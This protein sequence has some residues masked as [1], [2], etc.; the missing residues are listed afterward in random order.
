MRAQIRTQAISALLIG[1]WVAFYWAS[2]LAQ[3]AVSHVEFTDA[4]PNFSVDA[5]NLAAEDPALTHLDLYVKLTHQALQFIRTDERDFRADYAVAVEAYDSEGEK[6][7]ST[8]A[9]ETLFAENYD[10]TNSREL[11]HITRLGLDLEP[12]EYE[13]RVRVLDRETRKETAQSFPMSLRSYPAQGLDVSDIVYL[14]YLS[15]D[16]EGRLH[17]R[18]MVQIAKEASAEI[19]AYFEVYNVPENEDI[20]ISY[21]LLDARKEDVHVNE[22]T[23]KSRGRVTPYHI[24][25]DGGELPP[26]QYQL[27][28]DVMYGDDI[29]ETRRELAWFWQGLPEEFA[30]LHKA[31]EVLRYIASKEEMKELQEAPEEEK[32][33]AF[34][35]FWA[36]RDPTPGT[37]AN[38]LMEEY[39]RRIKYANDHFSGFKA[40]WKTDMGMVYVKLGPPDNIERNPYN[41]NYA[42]LPGRT[43]KAL[44]V[45]TYQMHNRNLV[46]LDENG[47]GEY[48][49]A[50][51][52]VFYDIVR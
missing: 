13:I 30:D 16:E 15:T 28:V 29:V 17:F 20:I 27:Q 21:E 47:F 19:L 9:E 52:H 39:Y 41:Q 26:G 33:D 31:I 2:G 44:E 35:Q 3:I 40:G 25:I 48:R 45:W 5:L 42:F 8:S 10:Q 51:P 1:A 6:V 50:N 18:P 49:L 22:V 7:G 23:V 12:G 36:E 34:I 14:D 38:E 11:F 24:E 43:V 4:R 37:E 46:F 32:H